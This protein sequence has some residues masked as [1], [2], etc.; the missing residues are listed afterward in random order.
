MRTAATLERGNEAEIDPN[1]IIEAELVD[2]APGDS[3]ATSSSEASAS[4]QTSTPEVPVPGS[5]LV[6]YVEIHPL[7]PR[8]EP[9]QIAGNEPTRLTFAL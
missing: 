2:E 5:E 8:E 3:E 6:P 7:P 4:S 1:N 9:R